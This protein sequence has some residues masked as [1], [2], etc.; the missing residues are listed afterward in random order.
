MGVILLPV[1][2]LVTT[3]AN[4]LSYCFQVE[5][6]PRQCQKLRRN[7]LNTHRVVQFNAVKLFCEMVRHATPTSNGDNKDVK[8]ILPLRVRKV[9]VS[10]YM[11][12]GIQ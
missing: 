11:G 1:C 8:T 9:V 3:T 7:F 6:Y 10:E 12:V 2:L 5:A 4:R